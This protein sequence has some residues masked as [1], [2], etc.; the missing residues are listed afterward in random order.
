MESR[1]RAKIPHETCSQ[2]NPCDSHYK[3]S[4]KNECI[5]QTIKI[6]NEPFCFSFSIL[7][8]SVKS[9]AWT[10]ATKHKFGC[11]REPRAKFERANVAFHTK[12]APGKRVAQLSQR[13]PYSHPSASLWGP[14]PLIANFRAARN[15]L[16]RSIPIENTKTNLKIF[17]FLNLYFFEPMKSVMTPFEVVFDSLVPSQQFLYYQNCPI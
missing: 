7:T 3:N 8:A 13:E 6:S 1:L 9:V 4:P 12:N 11:L 14:A 15:R 10:D 16:R 2:L 5:H 17:I